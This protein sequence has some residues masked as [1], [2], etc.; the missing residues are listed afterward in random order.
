MEKFKKLSRAEMKKVSGG[1]S[2]NCD[3]IGCTVYLWDGRSY[4]TGPGT[5]NPACI[6]VPNPG[7]EGSGGCSI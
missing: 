3:P 7:V 4:I 5:C 1:V 2:G 6:C